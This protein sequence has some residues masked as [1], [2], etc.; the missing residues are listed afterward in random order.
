MPSSES[1]VRGTAPSLASSRWPPRAL[2]LSARRI[3]TRRFSAQAA[4]PCPGAF[5]AVASSLVAVVGVLSSR[6]G[7]T[8]NVRDLI[9]R[10]ARDVQL[11]GEGKVQHQRQQEVQPD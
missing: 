11:A 10:R 3:S 6:T 5:G 1:E 8:G 4:R 2:T 9:E 7:A